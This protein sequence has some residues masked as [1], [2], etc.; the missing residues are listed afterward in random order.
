MGN[1]ANQ[2]EDDDATEEVRVSG[3]R[4]AI[5]V[6]PEEAA[7]LEL[8]PEE[9]QPHYDTIIVEPPVLLEDWAPL[10]ETFVLIPIT[11]RRDEV[12]AEEGAPQLHVAEKDEDWAAAR[13]AAKQRRVQRDRLIKAFLLRR[14]LPPCL[15]Q[16]V[17]ALQCTMLQVALMYSTPYAMLDRLM[18]FFI[19]A[20]DEQADLNGRARLMRSL[21]QELDNLQHRAALPRE[22]HLYLFR[23]LEEVSEEAP[24]LSGLAEEIV[25]DLRRDLRRADP[26]KLGASAQELLDT[27]GRRSFLS[28]LIISRART[29]PLLLAAVDRWL[30]YDGGMPEFEACLSLMG[31][32][33]APL[34][35]RTLTEARFRELAPEIRMDLLTRNN[36]SVRN[37]AEFLRTQRDPS[38]PL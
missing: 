7:A 14:L 24:L 13:L 8:L 25:L 35:Q 6:S 10:G 30:R 9:Q 18:G 26:A 36:A 23:N 12:P 15:F 1:P 29:K 37:F 16:Y 21:Q 11:G 32:L 33:Q 17:E 22:D 3:V 5:V 34:R 31:D 20:M 2:Q 4:L 28:D 27:E 38:S 19:E